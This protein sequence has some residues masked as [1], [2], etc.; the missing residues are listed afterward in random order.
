MTCKTSHLVHVATTLYKTPKFT[1]CSKIFALSGID[2]AL[3]HLDLVSRQAILSS[4]LPRSTPASFRSDVHRG[5]T[6]LWGHA[7]STCHS[8]VSCI[9][10]RNKHDIIYV[11]PTSVAR[12]IIIIIFGTL[13]TD[14]FW[15]S[16]WCHNLFM[17]VFLPFSIS[18]SLP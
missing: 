12:W 17:M 4:S 11:Y 8:H 1:T 7:T 6:N 2:M 13:I 15:S 16:P 9:I 18:L 3:I 10:C 14:D 5:L